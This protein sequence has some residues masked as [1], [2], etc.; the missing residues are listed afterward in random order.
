MGAPYPAY[1]LLG[2]ETPLLAAWACNKQ[3]QTLTRRKKKKIKNRKIKD[4]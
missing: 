1:I 2:K 3:D 4:K